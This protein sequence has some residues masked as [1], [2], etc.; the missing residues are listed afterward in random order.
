MHN[1]Y[2]YS[3]QIIKALTACS[4]GIARDLAFES[5]VDIEK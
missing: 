5:F 3:G 2:R 4:A 1:R